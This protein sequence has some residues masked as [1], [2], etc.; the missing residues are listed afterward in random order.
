MSNTMEL[1]F[2]A[3]QHRFHRTQLCDVFNAMLEYPEEI[4]SDILAPINGFLSVL[5]DFQFVFF[6]SVFDKIFAYTDV[7]FDVLQNQASDI[8]YCRKKIQDTRENVAKLRKDFKKHYDD[9]V[10]KVGPP[11][12]RRKQTNY[13]RVFCEILDNIDGHFETRFEDYSKL[14]FLQLLATGRFSDHEKD[15]PQVAFQA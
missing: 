15:F 9:T 3:C 14:D 6:L 12:K 5:D 4:E 13:V 11:K 1:L 10:A 7:L 8:V 2:Q